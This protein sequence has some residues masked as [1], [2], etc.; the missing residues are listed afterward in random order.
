MRGKPRLWARAI[1]N[2]SLIRS[3]EFDRSMT[4]GG[5][6][7]AERLPRDDDALDLLRALVD[8]R[9]LRIAHHALDRVFGH[10]AVAAEQLHRVG[11]HL[12]SDIAA[13]ELAQRAPIRDV[14]RA[15]V[16]L[17]RGLVEQQ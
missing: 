3:N 8:L 11:R 16:A 15:L 4:A 17:A 6:L 13:L 7:L 5:G 9:D 14:R 1:E 12:H 2:T 10:V